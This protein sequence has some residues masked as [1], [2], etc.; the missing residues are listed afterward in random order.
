MSHLQYFRRKDTCIFRT[1]DESWSSRWHCSRRDG[2]K[3]WQQEDKPKHNNSASFLALR[4]R[5]SA[6]VFFQRIRATRGPQALSDSLR[7]L[8]ANPVDAFCCISSRVPSRP[9]R[10][11]QH[12][13]V[14]CLCCWSYSFLKNLSRVVAKNSS[15]RDVGCSSAPDHRAR[16][17]IL[18]RCSSGI[19]RRAAYA[20]DVDSFHFVLLSITSW[21]VAQQNSP[22]RD[23]L[24]AASCRGGGG[25]PQHSGGGIQK[26]LPP[27]SWSSFVMSFPR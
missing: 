4:Y 23:T 3:V 22:T 20:R 12:R 9:R 5:G 14:C 6:F 16:L 27:F 24:T 18:T 8:Q 1:W 2:H 19:E 26:R 25:A 7:K 17:A 13:A 10:C 15:S 21:H 11:T